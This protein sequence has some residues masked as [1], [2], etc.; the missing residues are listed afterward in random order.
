LKG[1]KLNEK[2]NIWLEVDIIGTTRI[3]RR[4]IPGFGGKRRTR[5]GS[6]KAAKKTRRRRSY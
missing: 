1:K 5:R 4:F 2:V 6:K 3:I